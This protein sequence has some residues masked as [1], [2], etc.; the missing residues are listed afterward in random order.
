M[1]LKTKRV[2]EII[3]PPLP[4]YSYICNGEIVT[5]ECKGSMIFR[6]P[7]FITIQSQDVLSSFSISS[8]ISMKTR[9]R[10]RERWN[11][12]LIKYPLHLERDD[13]SFILSSNGFLTVYVDGIDICG[14]SGDVVYKEYRVIASKK[15][16][17]DKLNEALKLR[18]NLVI[19]E[20]RELWSFVT[21]FRVLYIEQNLRKELE[22]ILGVTR[23]ECNEIT[24][25]DGTVICKR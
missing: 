7:D 19:T 2:E 20:A 11:H 6:D 24:S 13:T 18:P 17:E 14:I 5:T 21:A 23:I 3:V 25:V 9:G 4:E 15:D 1:K 8:I 10:K 12:Y 22:K 16:F